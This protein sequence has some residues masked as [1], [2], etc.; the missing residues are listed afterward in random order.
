MNFEILK[1]ILNYITDCFNGIYKA[2]RFGFFNFNDFNVAEYEKYMQ[3]GNGD[4]NWMVP[5]KFLAFL[6]PSAENGTLHHPPE[7]YINYFLKNNVVA[8]V[9]LNRKAYT[10][11]RYLLFC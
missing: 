3:V 2:A 10:A 7:H 9:R 4:L 5:Q 11:S 8:V 6:G 1:I